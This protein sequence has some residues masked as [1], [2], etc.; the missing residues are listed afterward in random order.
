MIFAVVTGM[1][2]GAF[3]AMQFYQVVPETFLESVR[4]FLSPSDIFIVLL[5]GLIFG[6]IVAVNGCSWGLTTQGGAKE[7]GES[8]TTAVVTTWVAIF[9]MDFILALL[10][11]EKPIL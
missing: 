10:L 3:A 5:K 7:V 4:S 6:A 11:F 2:G 1:M 8:A 9:I